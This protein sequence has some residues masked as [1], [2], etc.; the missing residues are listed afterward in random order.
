M[1]CYANHKILSVNQ[2]VHLHNGFDI[3][4]LNPFSAKPCLIFHTR[5][6]PS[7]SEVVTTKVGVCWV[8]E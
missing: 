2:F 8:F 5:K 7:P 1:Y 4:A 3:N 6:V